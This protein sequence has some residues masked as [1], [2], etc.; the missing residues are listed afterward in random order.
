MNDD[1]FLSPYHL[2]AA[3]AALLIVLALLWDWGLFNRQGDTH[4]QDLEN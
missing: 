2:I 1:T 4:A 3:L